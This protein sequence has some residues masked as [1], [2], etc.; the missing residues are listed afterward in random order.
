MDLVALVPH[1]WRR[2]SSGRGVGSIL[3]CWGTGSQ[4]LARAGLGSSPRAHPT[5]PS[6]SIEQYVSAII[7]EPFIQGWLVLSENCVY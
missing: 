2:G 7:L 6:F 1:S 5:P 3:S 4:D